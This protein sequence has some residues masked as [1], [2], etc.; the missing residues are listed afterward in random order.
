[1]DSHGIVRIQLKK[2]K[3]YVMAKYTKEEVLAELKR[4]QLQERNGQQDIELT[5]SKATQ[6]S[7]HKQGHKNSS[8]RLGNILDVEFED[9]FHQ[10]NAHQYDYNLFGN[11]LTA[12]AN[13]IT[14]DASTKSELHDETTHITPVASVSSQT[15]KIPKKGRK[16]ANSTTTSTGDKKRTANVVRGRGAWYIYI[17]S[18]FVPM[19]IMGVVWYAM[20]IFPF[21]D[22]NLMA[23]DFGQQ[24]IDFYSFLRNTVRTGDFTSFFYSFSKSIGGPMVGNWGFYLMSP[25][26][27]IYVVLP[28]D[29]FNWAITFTIWLRYGAMGITF[30][31][32][33]V[34]RYQ[35]LLNKKWWVPIFA[36]MYALCGMN[37]AYQ[38]N[39]IFYDALIMLPLVMIGVETVLDGGRPFK[40]MIV[41]ALTLLFHFYMGY[42]IALFV[43]LY[44]FFYMARRYTRHKGI[45]TALASYIMPIVRL[46]LYSALGAALSLWI[47]LPI[48]MNLL[49]SKGAY[50]SSMTWSWTFQI[51]PLH[52]MSKFMLGAFDNEGWSS[53][54]N[55][56]NVYIAGVGLMSFFM[57]FVAKKV[58]K[59]EKVMAIVMLLIFFISIAHEFT[60]KIWHMGQSPA[61]FFYRFSWIISFFM[62]LLA[63]RAF[64]EQLKPRKIALFLVP[65]L[66]GGVGYYNFTQNFSFLN[67]WQIVASVALWC[68]IWWSFELLNY[69]L[70]HV[71]LVIITIAELGANAFIS[72]SRMNYYNANTFK[73]AQN[74]VMRE[75][76]QVRAS[77]DEFYRINKTFSRSRNDPFMYQYTG[78]TH[79]SSNMEKS[80]LDLFSHLGDSGSNAATYLGNATPL[81][82]AIFGVKYLIDRN[83][84]TAEDQQ[85]HPDY[86]WFGRESNRTDLNLYYNKVSESDRYTIY[87][88]QYALPVGFGINQAT[89]DL[90]FEKN[91]PGQ[92]QNRILQ[93]MTG[94]QDLNLFNTYAFEKIELENFHEDNPGSNEQRYTRTDTT[95]QGTIRLKFTP[96]TADTYYASA[97][98]AL[99]RM[100]GKLDIKLNGD[101]YPYNHSFDELQLWNL[102][103]NSQ[104]KEVVLEISTSS[105]NAVDLSNFYLIRS[106]T[107]EMI[108]IIESRQKQGFNVSEWGNNVMKGTINITDDSSYMLTSIPYN[109]GWRVEVDGK[110][111]QP[112]NVWESLMA[113]PITAG[114]HTINMTYYPPGFFI[115]VAGSAIAI[116]LWCMLW[117]MDRRRQYA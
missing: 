77:Q 10:N 57:F 65:I 3:E 69:K 39:P 44:S 58:T 22:K 20:G 6:A 56:P 116:L 36:A 25:F 54:P 63:F 108:P 64:Q 51:D 87:E 9:K 14:H 55:L 42:M 76:D 33:L 47:L 80:T 40:Y 100:K 102:A 103:T 30:A 91:Q 75:I 15:N 82:D 84:Y 62:V 71:V 68:I 67:P 45:G 4:R 112:R 37:V 90:I 17:L 16:K 109:E 70:I 88:N 97:T 114:Q 46:A 12:D 21:G 7:H 117:A 5:S 48:F 43:V 74:S 18:A 29:E 61:G 28:L 86:Y 110:Q 78:V 105:E 27:L 89:A 93:A 1:M 38:M 41:L 11:E 60:N 26:N 95:K 72:Q 35:A 32:L 83:N 66:I 24:Y 19:L 23:I 99:K 96:K 113:I 8:D 59:S 115:G 111:V 2:E 49:E 31:M 53:G 106:S 34:K 94:N 50:S 107:K 79:F 52:I 92:T 85:K 13:N 101:W 81:T 98:L 73:D 104:D